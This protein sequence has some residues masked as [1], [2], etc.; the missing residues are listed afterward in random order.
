MEE[1]IRWIDTAKFLGIFA[2]Y[3]GHFGVQAGNAYKFVFQY[4]V[5]LFFLLSGCMSRYDKE[6]NFI[7]FLIKK[8]KSIL[9]PFWFFS[10][11]SIAVYVIQCNE[12]LSTTKELLI[13][14]AKGN[15][16]NTFFAGALWF[17]SCLF[18]MEIIYK[19]LK[20]L[21]KKWIIFLICL[22]MYMVAELVIIPRPIVEPHWYYNLDSAF[23]YMIFFTIGDIIY[24][25]LLE[26]FKLDTR[27]KKIIFAI[28]GGGSFVYSALLFCENDCLTYVLVFF[29]ALALFTPIMKALLVI[30]FN[31]VIARAVE[32]ISL[33]NEIGRSTLY[34]CGNESIV[35][36]IIPCLVETIGMGINLPS[37]L[38]TYLYTAI[39]LVICLKFIIP[40]EKRLLNSIRGALS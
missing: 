28:S 6:N 30:W 8:I 11:L 34:L 31:F 35:K 25:Y 21:K 36:T 32:N 27:W 37:P 40:I 22:A 16:R 2:I 24:P 20:L 19:V 5:P 9:I 10:L 26:L 18:C 14:V 38:S 29:P 1:R 7:R 23:Y 13:L 39:L 12:G 17:L 15:I 4:H 3:L 33:F